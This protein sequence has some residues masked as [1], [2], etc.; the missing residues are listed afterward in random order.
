M[1]ADYK[2]QKNSELEDLEIEAVLSTKKKVRGK[3]KQIPYR[4]ISSSLTYMQLESQRGKKG[5][6]V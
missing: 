1:T 5:E 3:N 6:G 4:I 2:L